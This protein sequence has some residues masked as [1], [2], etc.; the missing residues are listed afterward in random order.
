MGSPTSRLLALLESL[1]AQPVA[2]GRELA[3]RLGIDVRTLRRYIA[4]L[5]ELGIPVEGQRGVGGGYR[6]RPG[7]RL[8]PLMLSDDET[9]VMVLG[10]LAARRLGLD[11]ESASAEGALTKIHRVLP[12]RLRSRAEA[13]EATLGFTDAVGGGVPVPGETV[14]LVAEAVRR[15]K[16]L[17]TRY[18]SFSGDL[19]DRDLSRS[20]SSSTPVAGTS[21]RTTTA[22]AS[23]APSG[24]TACASPLSRTPPPWRRRTASIPSPTSAARSRAFHGRGKSRWSSSFPWSEPR[25]A[26]PPRSGS[27]ARRAGR[28]CSGCRWSPSTGWRPFSQV[29]AATSRSGD[30][31]SCAR[32]CGSSR[33]V[34]RPSEAE[35]LAVRRSLAVVPESS[36]VTELLGAET[37]P[38]LSTARSGGGLTRCTNSRSER[39]PHAGS[40]RI[41]VSD[42]ERSRDFYAQALAPLEFTLLME[43]RPRTGGFGVGVKPTFWITDTREPITENVHVAVPG[44]R[45]GNR[46]RLSRRRA[47]G[48]RHRQRPAGTARALSPERT[49]AGSSWIP[50]ATTWKRSATRRRRRRSQSTSEPLVRLTIA[51]VVAPARSEAKKAAASATSASVG[52]RPSTCPAATLRPAFPRRSCR[53]A[54]RSPEKTS[55]T[56]DR[57]EAPPESRATEADDADAAGPELAG[58]DPREGLDRRAGHPV[59]QEPGAQ[60]CVIQGSRASGSRRTPA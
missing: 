2:T 9:V 12:D 29:L 38:A 3:D 31:M 20:A 53:P 7:Y 42:Y 35:P 44:C 60:S 10:L 52:K 28:R 8:P 19:S 33:P 51:P 41:N 5:Q 4:A 45:S 37:L 6:L 15:R 55:R 40:R 54:R 14:L 26:S 1:Q 57:R 17:R 47:R 18:R 27:W 25:S 50:T 49:T 21:Q 59:A 11:T 30:R 22:A 23:S 16:R 48:G 24:S 43:P 34:S 13:L 32:A 39:R 36:R 56:C 46:G 58:Q